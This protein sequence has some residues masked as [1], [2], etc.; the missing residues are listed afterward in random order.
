MQKNNNVVDILLIR[1]Q[2][3][4]NSFS[5]FSK[6]TLLE[7]AFARWRH[8]QA[9]LWFWV[10]QVISDMLRIRNIAKSLWTDCYCCLSCSPLPKVFCRK[11]VLNFWKFHRKTPV[12][13]FLFNK[14]AGLHYCFCIFLSSY[15]QSRVHDYFKLAFIS[16][17]FVGVTFVRLTTSTPTL[18]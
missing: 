13:H 2:Q 1:F 18:S 17:A 8:F 9:N 14:V 15:L 12:L 11:S 4:T 3:E 10:L 5:I 7:Q 6:N 16:N